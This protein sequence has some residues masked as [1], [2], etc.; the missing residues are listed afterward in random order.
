MK[1]GNMLVMGLTTLALTPSSWA[2]VGGPWD[3][4][5]KGVYSRQNTDGLYEA[6]ISM[7]NGSGFLRFVSNTGRSTLADPYT[8][9][10]GIAIQGNN[11]GATATNTTAGLA[12]RSN[13][14]IFYKGNAYYGS[15]YGTVNAFSKTVSGGGGGQS[16]VVDSVETSIQQFAQNI[17]AFVNIN[18]FS[19]S[20]NI[21]FNGRIVSQ[22]PEIRFEAKGEAVFFNRPDIEVGIVDTDDNDI[23]D[24]DLD[25]LYEIKVAE[26]GEI[27]P[28]AT[29]K[30]RL[31]GGRVNLQTSYANTTLSSVNNGTTGN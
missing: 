18:G 8:V 7:K 21:T 6:S 23:F 10:T 29:R 28:T 26:K 2:W 5:I 31:L 17:N 14:V 3:H 30:I 4:L 19:E 16:S 15:V 9:T 1:L 25:E 20:M 22:T 27:K 24:I 11:V 12:A 13:T